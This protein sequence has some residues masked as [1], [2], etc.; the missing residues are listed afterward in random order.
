[1][2][3]IIIVILLIY[4]GTMVQAQND[5]VLPNNYLRNSIKWNLTPFLVWSLKDINISYERV[6]S[7]YKSFSVN[8]GYFE[9]P[10]TSIY[11]SLH[12]A[13]TRKKW[14]FTVSGDYRFY[15]KKRN[16]NFAPDGLFWGAYSSFHYTTFENDILVFKTDGAQGNINLHAQLA[17]VSAGVELGYQFVFD[18][19][20]SVDIV[21]AA[22]ALSV[23][24]GD[25]KLT[26][27]LDV[28][29]ND[30]Y[31]KAIRDM[32]LSFFPFLGNMSSDGIVSVSGTKLSLGMGA[33][34]LVQIGYRF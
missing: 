7:P 8:A 27:D 2:K 26:G 23:Y 25:L 17:I 13:A 14:G 33:R 10:S 22:P 21:F 31:L 1:M 12:I 15:A 4:A 30:E 32:L 6:L 9:L 20:L 16:K 29:E 28:D 34:Y 18:K 19:H 24:A 5:T 11:D 3:K